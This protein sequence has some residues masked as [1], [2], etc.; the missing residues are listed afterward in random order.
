MEQPLPW[1]S[2]PFWVVFYISWINEI[3]HYWLKPV[4]HLEPIVTR[5][6]ITKVCT[7]HT[8]VMD[9]ARKELG[10]APKKF[11]VSPQFFLKIA[12]LQALR[13]EN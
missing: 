1:I 6:E 7:T 3:L 12:L 2:I 9:K 4:F 10:Y 11:H 13:S 5:N 8:C